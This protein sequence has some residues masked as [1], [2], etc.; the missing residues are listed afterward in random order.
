MLGIES[1]DDGIQSDGGTLT[2]DGK[3]VFEEQYM[4]QLIATNV[5]SSFVEKNLHDCNP[6]VPSVMMN[7]EW[8]AISLYDCVQ[9]HLIL[10]KRISLYDDN[11]AP[12]DSVLLLLWLFINH[13]YVL[14]HR[15]N[16]YPFGAR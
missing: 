16:R 5:V 15:Y 2:I 1:S 12:K 10:T 8:V 7:G 3:A 14:I 4:S 6:L 11:W 9:D 13:R